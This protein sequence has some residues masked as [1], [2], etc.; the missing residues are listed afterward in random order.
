MADQQLKIRIDAIDNATKALK[1]VKNQ[2][3][4][5]GT[6]TTKVASSFSLLATTIA[7]VIGATTVKAV[8]DVSK[9]F[10]DLRSTLG[11]VTGSAKSGGNA[12]NFLTQYAKKSTF[13]VNDLA[14]TFIT[15]YSAGINPTEE[16]LQ[17]FTDTASA[18]TDQ[19]DT[20][21]DLT[22]L[23]AKG[24]EGGIGLQSLNQLASKGIPVFRILKEQ[25]GLAREDINKFGESAEGSRQI[26][27]ALQKGLAKT[28]FGATASRA[29]DLSVSMSRLYKEVQI[30]LNI[31]GE[32]GFS[33]SLSQATKSLGEFVDALEPVFVGLGKLSGF[34]L[35][36]TDG[37]FKFGTEVAKALKYTIK[38]EIDD[39]KK[40]TDL[41]YKNIF[42]KDRVAK[43]TTENTVVGKGTI[44]EISAPV[45]DAKTTTTLENI[46]SKFKILSADT[47]SI[48]DK[49]AG[50]LVKGIENFSQ[51]LAEAIVLGKSLQG[52]LKAVGQSILIDILKSQISLIAKLL[53]Q[54]AIEKLITQQKVIQSSISG[55]G[56]FLGTIARIG[57][58]AIAG[59]GSVPLDAPNLYNPVMEAEG[60]ALSAGNPYMVGERGRELFIPSTNG[61][62]IPNHDLGGGT[63]ITFNIQAN[64][65]R[66]IK[67]LLID[68]R[69]TIINLVNQGANAKGKSNIV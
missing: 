63:N 41:M 8:Y 24:I 42:G 50:G 25:I 45:I 19:L 14:N 16:L 35:D 17:T 10:Q 58:N 36:A 30:A 51:G 26:L 40:A 61:T 46:L 4:N 43:V 47:T 55:G 18:T 44:G 1:E 53:T 64:D 22:R 21:N 33:K 38:Q 49:I 5:V 60:G 28:Y 57:F 65:V 54:L 39:I 11:F 52:T 6:T 2:L 37:A 12:L 48:A 3:Q 29:D 31:I 13:S 27:D 69:A 62:M 15:L 34:F 9:N 32:N 68:N 56:G 67:E 23:F 20:L 59:G 66:G 7:T